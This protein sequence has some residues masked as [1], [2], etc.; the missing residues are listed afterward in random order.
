[1]GREQLALHREH[2]IAQGLAS[3]QRFEVSNKLVKL[4][5]GLNGFPGEGRTVSLDL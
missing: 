5:L 3:D 1:M 2:H 4:K